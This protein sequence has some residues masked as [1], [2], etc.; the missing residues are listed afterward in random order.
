MLRRRNTKY[1]INKKAANDTL[2]SVFEACEQEPNSK[3]LELIQAWAIANTTIVKVGMW[4]S[5]ALL[6]M[7]LVMPLAFVSSREADNGLGEVD[8]VKVVEHYLDVD[9]DCF[10]MVLYGNG[11]DYNGIYALRDDGRTV[12][13]QEIDEDNH[14]VKIPFVEG[15]LNIYIPKSDGTFLQAVLSK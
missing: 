3:P 10:V 8:N 12:F 9:N 14:T 11:I 13:P 2:Q 1:V 7:V 5:V 4:M 6:V 15:N